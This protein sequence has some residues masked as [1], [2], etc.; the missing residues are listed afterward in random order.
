V[1]NVQRTVQSA[2]SLMNFSGTLD[3]RYLSQSLSSYYSQGNTLI[4]RFALDF[5]RI[6]ATHILKLERI[7]YRCLSIVLE[8]MQS[9]HVQTLEVIGGVPPLRLRFSMLNQKYLISAFSTGNGRPLRRSLALLS[10]LNSTKM[11]R[12]FDMVGDYDLE[13]VRSVYVYPLEALLYVPN[14]NDVVEQELTSVGRDFYQMVVLQLMASATPGLDS[15]SIFF[16]DGSKGGASTGFGVYHSGG[17]ES[18]FCL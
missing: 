12:E 6:A 16:T 4:L 3:S 9:T 2:S 17:H 13:P 1:E 5:D 15:S 14:V 10:R 7:Q 8:L 18:S 11:V